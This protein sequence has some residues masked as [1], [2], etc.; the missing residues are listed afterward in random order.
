ML[1]YII[2]ED[3]AKAIGTELSGSGFTVFQYKQAKS[4]LTLFGVE[5]PSGKTFTRD[6]RAAAPRNAKGV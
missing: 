5:L 3:Q 4:N 1:G 2:S 6:P